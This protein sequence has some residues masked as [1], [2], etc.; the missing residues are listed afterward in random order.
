M[1][2]KKMVVVDPEKI[3][4]E[5]VVVKK[6]LPKGAWAK[7]LSHDEETGAMAMLAKFDKGF[8]ESKV[9]HPSD[10]VGMVLEG[11][12]VDERGNE[13]KKGMYWFIPAGVEHGCTV[14]APEGCVV[15]VYF[16][17]PPW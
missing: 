17:G 6:Q 3:E 10:E 8:H 15:F 12:W 16:N 7:V 9:T 14:D 4:W 5:T 13:I 11:K 2:R 1:A